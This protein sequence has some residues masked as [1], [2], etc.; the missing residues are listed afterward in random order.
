MKKITKISK[1]RN[2][3]SSKIKRTTLRPR[4]IV[5]RSLKH[6]S[7]QIV[8]IKGNVIAF[9]SDLKDKKKKPLEKAQRVGEEI[10]SKAKEKKLNYV[11]FDRRGYKYHGRI[12]SLAEGARKAGLEF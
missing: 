4:L 5:S 6:I 8:D 9:S 3:I 10:A 1:R 12:K 7:A 2:K 11:V